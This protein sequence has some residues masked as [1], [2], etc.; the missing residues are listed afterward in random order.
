MP[1]IG[2]L[3]AQLTVLQRD[4]IHKQRWMLVNQGEKAG[5]VQPN[6]SERCQR[7]CIPAVAL[8]GQNQILVEKQLPCAV[9]DA[10]P[11][12]TGQLHQSLF[13]DVNRIDKV[14]LSE[15]QG[16]RWQG[17]PTTFT[18]L[19][20]Q[21]Q[22]C[23]GVDACAHAPEGFMGDQPSPDVSRMIS[24]QSTIQLQLLLA[25]IA[26]QPMQGR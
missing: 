2:P 12:T 4:Q 15:H 25:V 22:W 14:S 20:D 17:Q 24:N 9:T 3:L 13:H 1:R 11:S 16:P 18:M 19:A 26:L 6:Q 5:A 21:R 10:T 7:L 23:L 8:I